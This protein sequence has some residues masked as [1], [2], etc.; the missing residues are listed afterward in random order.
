MKNHSAIEL[1]APEK[2]YIFVGAIY[3]IICFFTLPF[4][5]LLFSDGLHNDSRVL[6]WF[7]IAF[8]LMNLFVVGMLYK[9]FLEESLLNLQLNKDRAISVIAITV[10]LMLGIG[11]IWHFLYLFTGILGLEL[12]AFG[13]VPLSEMDIFRLSGL[14]VLANPVFGT[15]CMVVVVPVVTCCLYYAL[16]FGPFYNIRPWLGY[17]VVCAAV[18]FPRICC[19]VTFWDPYEEL[20]LYLAQLPVHLVSCWAY[21]KTGTIWTPIIAHMIANLIACIAF[22]LAYKL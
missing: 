15:L 11:L 16:G 4:L 18:A 1:E 7:E 19:A 20:M 2:Q 21:K 9:E 5:L 10:G 13:T 12:A 22:L 6:S 14:V 17:L 3:S 8:H